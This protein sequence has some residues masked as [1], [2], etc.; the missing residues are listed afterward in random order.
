[1]TLRLWALVGGVVALSGASLL[2]S[3]RVAPTLTVDRPDEPPIVWLPA[4]DPALEE[5]TREARR[6]V[7]TFLA[8]LARTQS[9]PSQAQLKVRIEE[10]DIVEHVWLIDLRYEKGMLYGA[11]GNEPLR[12]REWKRGDPAMVD[13]AEITD[14][15]LIN[16]DGLQGGFTLRAARERI[17]P[18]QLK[19]FNASFAAH[20]GVDPEGF[21]ND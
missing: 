4:D 6:T 8:E 7:D 2:Y 1:M 5:A 19:S 20:F 16:D 17:S 18:A 13:P 11:L 9:P 15:L 14:W 3:V 12:L 10:G 21:F